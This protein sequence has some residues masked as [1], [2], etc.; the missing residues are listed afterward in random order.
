MA[1]TDDIIKTLPKA[2]G[3]YI[4]RDSA[5]KIIYIGKANDLRVRLRSYLGQDDRPFTGRIV[6]KTERVE[7]VLTRNETEALLLENQL[8]KEHS[9]RYNIDLKDDKSYV[10]IKLTVGNEWPGIYVTRKVV[11]DGSRYFGPYS[12]ARSTR[13]TLSAIGRIF[14]VRRCTDT[15]FANRSRPCIFHYIG[16]CMAPCVYKAIWKEYG[17]AVLDLIAFLEG[18]NHDLVN[19]LE[20]RM[21]EESDN[22]NFE[23]AARIRDQI[24]AIRSTL[25]PQVVTGHTGTDTDV[26]SFFRRKN[27]IQIAVVCISQ[28]NMSDSFNYTFRDVEEDDI[29]AGAILQFYLKH[30]EIPVRIYTDTLPRSIDTLEEV[31]SNMRGSR[32]RI[33]KPARGRPLQWLSIA[34]DNART[35]SRREGSSVSVLEEIAKAFHL[36]SVPYR[37][38][39]YD[40]SNIQGKSAAGSRVVFVDGEPDKTLYR[41]YRIQGMDTP[42]DFAMLREIFERRLMHDET[43]PDLIVIDGGKGQLGVFLKVLEEL[44]VPRMPI[45]S[46]A[47]AKGG[48]VDRFFLPGRKDAVRLPERSRALRTLQRLRDE[49]HRFAIKYHR[50]LRSRRSTSLFEGIP[51]IGPKKARALLMYTSNLTDLSQITPE[52]LSGIKGL[53]SK[54][55]ENIISYLK[56][57][58]LPIPLIFCNDKIGNPSGN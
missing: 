37:M 54:D 39:C 57:E 21:K 9:P 40:I 15:F 32:V 24:A 25:T 17:Q 47:K 5:N 49:A 38:E 4:L 20:T 13:N 48:R 28:G 56:A 11:K 41:H 30:Q 53:S 26:F 6:E 44:G 22:L 16:L 45:V 12:S 52:D 51:G 34:Q 33:Y 14:P 36:S 29:I 31:L 58:S 23:K 50:Q 8:I 46:I 18:K 1:L 3:V 35:H 42:D 2:T 7:Y 43:R 19:M 55:R 27:A 10:R